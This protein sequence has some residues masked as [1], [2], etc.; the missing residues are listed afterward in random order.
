M[1]TRLVS[2]SRH[3]VIHLLTS[4]SQNARLTGMSHHI[5][6][7]FFFLME[8]YSILPRLEF[9]AKI[10]AH[11]SFYLLGSSDSPV[12]ASGGAGTLGMCHH[13]WLIFVLLVEMVFHHVGHA[14]L[15]LLTSGDP[16]ASASQSAGITGVSH[17]ARP[18]LWLLFNSAWCSWELPKLLEILVVSSFYTWV[19]FNYLVTAYFRHSYICLPVNEYLS[20]PISQFLA[21]WMLLLWTFMNKP[22]L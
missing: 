3:Q 16:P 22:F 4:A 1:L 21:I 11:C 14:G 15:K 5:Q 12:S 18:F 9:N 19:V 10:L 17:R 7:F 20:F 13:A 2:N 6:A 8:S